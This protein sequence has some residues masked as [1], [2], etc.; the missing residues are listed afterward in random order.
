MV[1]YVQISTWG[2]N[3]NNT[4]GKGRVMGTDKQYIQKGERYR[5]ILLFYYT[6]FV[7]Q[8]PL[9]GVYNTTGKG[10]GEAQTSNTLRKGRWRGTDKQYSQ[11]GKVE[12]H[13]QAILSEKE[14]GEAQTSNTLGRWRG[15]DK[16]YSRKVERHRQAILSEGGEAHTSNTLGRWRGT[17]KQYSRK[18]ERHR[19]AI[20]C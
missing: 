17:D 3:T 2:Y 15:T 14:G 9:H 11:K 5:E 16:Q 20:H 1:C 18:V 7:R 13:R 19:Q 8:R 4:T 12:R 6:W 10:R